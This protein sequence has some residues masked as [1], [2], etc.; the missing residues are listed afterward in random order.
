MFE[1]S[2]IIKKIISPS[3]DKFIYL[4]ALQEENNEVKINEVKIILCILV[5][6]C[7]I[8]STSNRSSLG[9]QIPFFQKNIC[10]SFFFNSTF[11]YLFS[12][13]NILVIFSF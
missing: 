8:I 7:R 13:I 11:Y 10:F 6:L 12:K 3:I 4:C 2:E 9:S 5:I 1:F